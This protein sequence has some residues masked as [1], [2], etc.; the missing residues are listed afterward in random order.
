MTSRPPPAVS[1]FSFI[2]PTTTIAITIAIFVV[3]TITNFE[4]AVSSLY[5]AVVLLAVNSST[6]EVSCSWLPAASRLRY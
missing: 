2:L 4:I 5:G 1:Y 3:D 6:P